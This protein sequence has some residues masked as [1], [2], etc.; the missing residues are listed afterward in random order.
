MANSFENLPIFKEAHPLVLTIYKYTKLF[1][2]EEKFGLVSQLRRASSSIIANIVEG[3][4]RVHPK[5]VVNFLL[6][7]KGSL[8]ETKY[9]ILLSRDLGYISQTEYESTAAQTEIVGR[10]L[11]GLLKYWKGKI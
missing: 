4:T 3:N 6:I 8:E 9:F 1:P 7:A 10:Q 5:E 11:S 2:Q